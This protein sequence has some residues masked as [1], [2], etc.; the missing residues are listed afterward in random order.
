VSRA[1]FFTNSGAVISDDGVYRYVLWRAWSETRS[2]CLF[3]MLN[4]STAD[5]T[6]DDPTIRRCISFAKS[7]GCGSLEVVNLFA[8]RATKP[9][10]LPDDMLLAEGPSNRAWLKKAV[11]NS[12]LI[13]AAW[14]S[15]G[16]MAS[17]QITFVKSIVSGRRP[18]TLGLTKM[19]QP[20]H[21]LFVPVVTKLVAWE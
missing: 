8:Y 6:R 18:W 11:N 4:P 7:W 12:N 10:D 13:V 5:R 9:I 19:G 21:P 1:G 2:Q 15:Y 3:I 17:P 14:G 20:R 16:Y